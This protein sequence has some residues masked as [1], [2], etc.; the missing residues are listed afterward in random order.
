MSDPQVEASDPL[1]EG[2]AGR[3]VLVTGGGGFAGSHLVE[4]LVGYGAEVTVV[5]NFQSGRPENLAQVADRVSIVEEPLPEALDAVSAPDYVFHMAARSYVPPSVADPEG[6]LRTNAGLALHV[7]EW[8]RNH[9]P[10]TKVIIF[11]SAAVY[12]SPRSTPVS[13]DHPLAPV[14]PYGVSK[15]AADRYANIYA[16]VFGLSTVALRCFALFG[17]RH[18]K[19]VVFDLMNKLRA[20]QGAAE[21]IG[22]GEE[23]RDLCYVSDIVR[24][25]CTV[26]LR[27]PFQGEVYNAGG[28]VPIKIGRLAEMIAEAMG[29]E[30]R[31][32]FTGVTRP[33]DPNVLVADVSRLRALD[34]EPRTSLEEGLQRTAEWFAGLTDFEV[35][36]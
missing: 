35:R 17:P 15:L 16:S 34:W 5:D 4:A 14:S 12:G 31:L 36:F 20:G 21:V 18:R 23:E 1:A 11:S 19:Q 27:A 6:D 33:G 22:T 26:A 8:V 30:P 24:A 29:F 28:T 10:Q 32:T 3:Q 13:E 2:W 7:L 9:T 25:A